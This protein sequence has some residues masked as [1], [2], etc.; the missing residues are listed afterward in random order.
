MVVVVVGTVVVVVVGSVVVVVVEVVPPRI[1]V[2]VEL[3]VVVGAIV[4]VGTSVVVVVEVVVDV[5]VEVVVEVV[6]V[7]V[8]VVGTGPGRH[9]VD[10]RF[11]LGAVVVEVTVTGF[12][13]VVVGTVVV[14]VAAW[15]VMPMLVTR[16]PPSTPTTSSVV[17]AAGARRDRRAILT[18]REGVRRLGTRGRSTGVHSVVDHTLWCS[19]AGGALRGCLRPRPSTR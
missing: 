18:R 10:I 6:V 7:V 12:A 2:V 15:L 4:V 11:A 19:A 8:V 17:D 3:D 14:T 16:L 9:V 5:V 13:I 1:V